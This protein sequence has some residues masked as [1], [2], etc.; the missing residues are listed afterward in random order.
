MYIIFFETD[1][2]LK[3]DTR[4]PNGSDMCLIFY[5][6]EKRKQTIKGTQLTGL[7]MS[8]FFF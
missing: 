5:V 3:L 6:H 4:I 7:V 1:M 8:S 2:R